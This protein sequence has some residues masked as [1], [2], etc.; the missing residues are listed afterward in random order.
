MQITLTPEY[1][2]RLDVTIKETETHRD[3]ELG[4]LEHLR[5]KDLLSFYEAHLKKLTDIRDLGVGATLEI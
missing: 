4:Y 1:I 5:N 3:R 2:A